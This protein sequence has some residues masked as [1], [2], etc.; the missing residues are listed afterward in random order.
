MHR[1][2]IPGCVG[3][4]PP[5]EEEAVRLIHHRRDL[6]QTSIDVGGTE[7]DGSSCEHDKSVRDKQIS[8]DAATHN[9]GG[10]LT[11]C[12]LPL[13]G[14]R[15]PGHRGQ[16]RWQ[17]VETRYSSPGGTVCRHVKMLKLKE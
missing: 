17:A 15:Q 10:L 9:W 2:T 4:I 7:A 1:K 8:S 12:L 5:P 6:A 14:A 13:G 11:A 3:L 16:K